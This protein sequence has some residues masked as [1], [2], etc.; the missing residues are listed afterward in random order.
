MSPTE[1]LAL[2][3]LPADVDALDKTLTQLV[4][5]ENAAKAKGA[6]QPAGVTAKALRAAET[7]MHEAV[8][9]MKSRIASRSSAAWSDHRI[10]VTSRPAA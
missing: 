10:A 3:I 8:G 6:G 9:R 4:A 2:G 5:A 1:A 7:R